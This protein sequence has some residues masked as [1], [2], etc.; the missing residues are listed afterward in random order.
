MKQIIVKMVKHSK[1]AGNVSE[2]NITKLLS[3]AESY[4]QGLVLTEGHWTSLSEKEIKKIEKFMKKLKE[5]EPSLF[6]SDV[7]NNSIEHI[8]TLYGEIELHYDEKR[9]S[10]YC[11][12]NGYIKEGVW[13]FNIIQSVL[14]REEPNQGPNIKGAIRKFH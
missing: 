8:K 5:E 10:L 14:G 1:I 13:F 12:T 9:L 11:S 2:E 4:S 3:L 6:I 7:R